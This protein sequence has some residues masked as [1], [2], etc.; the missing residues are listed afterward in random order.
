MQINK[1]QAPM[2]QKPQNNNKSV[3]FKGNPVE[4]AGKLVGKGSLTKFADKIEFDSI[5]MPFPVLA[6]VMIFGVIIPR[7][8]QAQDEY[9]RE[10]IMRRDLISTVVI[11]TAQPVI[12]KSISAITEAK[13]GLALATKPA[14]KNGFQKVLS[15]LNPVGGVRVLN[16]DQIAAKYSKID[17]YKNGIAGFCDFVTG[18]GGNLKKMFSYEK[19]GTKEIVEKIVGKDIFEAGDNK[20]IRDALADAAKKGTKEIG[21]LYAKFADKNN[22]FVIKAK[23]L[24]STFGFLSMFLLVP[25]LLGFA[26]PKVNERITKKKFL[27]RQAAEQEK[28]QNSIRN[29]AKL[30][31]QLKSPLAMSNINVSTKI[32]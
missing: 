26:I 5:N 6:T 27:E 17:G 7:L 16:G 31:A 3:A 4:L 23:S 12:N 13:S 22:P 8:V 28:A 2:L 30:P 1:I 14:T 18:N 21:E 20:A 32:K 29:A 25:A 15:Y 24:N 9:D 10:E 11:T 19:G